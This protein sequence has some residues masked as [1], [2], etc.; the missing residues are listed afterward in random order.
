M[1]I[2][3]RMITG[4]DRRE[5]LVVYQHVALDGDLEKGV[6]R[7]H[8]GS[9]PLTSN[10]HLTFAFDGDT[11]SVRSLHDGITSCREKEWTASDQ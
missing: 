10:R 2:P 4:H 5:T 7:D 3:G 9:G 8:A 1:D 6:S 11:D